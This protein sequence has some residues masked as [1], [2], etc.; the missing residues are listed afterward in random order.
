MSN[1][2]LPNDPDTQAEENAS[3]DPVPTSQN[4]V[5][6]SSTGKSKFR[7]SRFFKKKTASVINNAIAIFALICLVQY[8]QVVTV[9]VK[10]KQNT[11]IECHP[12][13]FYSSVASNIT[14]NVSRNSIRET[15]ACNSMV[16][17]GANG[18]IGGGKN[19]RK[20]CETGRFV[21]LD[22]FNLYC[23]RNGRSS[24][25]I[26]SMLFSSVRISF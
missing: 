9:S 21:T 11:I 7:L 2:Q 23:G 24:W 4:E 12:I 22:W 16:D 1:A 10:E 19:T 5:T 14:Y 18:G 20:V 26:F 3:Y 17:G 13:M 15:P 25:K 6:P 8:P